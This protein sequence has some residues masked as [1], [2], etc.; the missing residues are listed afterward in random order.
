MFCASNVYL[1]NL[2]WTGFTSPQP[3]VGRVYPSTLA[4]Y[5]S[6]GRVDGSLDEAVLTS[7]L[8]SGSKFAIDL[9]SY[10]H[11]I[12]PNTLFAVFVTFAHCSL[13]LRFSVTIMPRS[14]SCVAIGTSVPP[15]RYVVR[16]FPCPMCRH[17]HLSILFE[18]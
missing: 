2:C 14:F 9:S 3:I 17:F 8:Q 15:S 18:T 13:T 1:F 10:D 11:F 16:L 4:F 6:K 5:P 12:I 7:A